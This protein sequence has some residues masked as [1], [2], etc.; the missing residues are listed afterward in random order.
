MIVE[1]IG[2][3]FVTFKS[4]NQQGCLDNWFK[5]SSAHEFLPLSEG[6]TLPWSGV[7]LCVELRKDSV[8][9]SSMK[10]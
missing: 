7:M 1:R 10:E 9:S 3:K 4:R 8:S 6:V 5:A 2:I